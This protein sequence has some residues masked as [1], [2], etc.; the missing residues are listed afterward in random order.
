MDNMDWYRKQP[1]KGSGFF[2]V[3]DL[4]AQ[5][6]WPDT[7][8]GLACLI[9]MCRSDILNGYPDAFD[10]VDHAD[11]ARDVYRFGEQKTA[12]MNAWTLG[13][14]LHHYADGE[15]DVLEPALKEMETTS[16]A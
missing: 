8:W 1:R 15:D 14:L 6:N 2:S 12:P 10:A 16:A 3:L 4:D 7:S 5:V 13:Q 9:G 11:Y